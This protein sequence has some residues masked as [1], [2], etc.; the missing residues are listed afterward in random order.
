MTQIENAFMEMLRD[1]TRRQ[2]E[3]V[4]KNNKEANTLFVGRVEANTIE[5]FGKLRDPVTA[6]KFMREGEG[7]P[8]TIQGLRIRMLNEFS[9]LEVAI[10]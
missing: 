5:Q 4:A 3:F 7:G 9:A 6:V 2:S 10:V 1:V 8:L